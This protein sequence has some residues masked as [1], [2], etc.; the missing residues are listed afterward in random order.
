MSTHNISFREFLFLFIFTIQF[1]SFIVIYQRFSNEINVTLIISFDHSIIKIRF[2]ILNR[3]NSCVNDRS[4]EMKNNFKTTLKFDK[5]KK[6]DFDKSQSVINKTV[7]NVLRYSFI[8]Y[9]S[10]DYVTCV[11][12]R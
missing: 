5:F 7:K 4:I 2:T 1:Y 3:F 8:F 12:R 10:R 9:E 6:S 11:I